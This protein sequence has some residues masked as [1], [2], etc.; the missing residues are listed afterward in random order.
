VA[1][2]AIYVYD[3]LPHHL[4]LSGMKPEFIVRFVA[5]VL[6]GAG[7]IRVVRS[8][9]ATR[10]L[11]AFGAATVAIALIG[12]VLSIASEFSQ[13]TFAGVLRYYWFRLADIVVPLCV[14]LFAAARVDQAFVRNPVRGSYLAAAVMLLCAIHLGLVLYERR[15]GTE[16][17]RYAPADA[18]SRVAIGGKSVIAAEDWKEIC[19]RFRKLPISSDAKVLTPRNSHSFKWHAGLPEVGTWKDIPQDAKSI[20]EWMDRMHTIHRNRD[21][22]T[23]ERR[24]SRT[25]G[26][27]GAEELVRVAREYGAEYIVAEAE[28]TVALEKEWGNRSFTIYRVYSE[29]EP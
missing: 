24:W 19:Y 22:K 15:A 26:E 4:V 9:P 12:A 3:R 8:T 13:P 5:M 2:N 14:A 17:A 25:L 29:R 27:L 28:P 23:P 6:V 10:G 18:K 11:A 16:I 7:L 20:V 21:P 1:A